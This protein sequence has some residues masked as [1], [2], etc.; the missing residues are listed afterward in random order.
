MQA[1]DLNMFIANGIDPRTKKT[2]A[3]KSMQHFRAAFEPIA[4]KV[5]VADSGALCSPDCTRLTYRSVRR[6][7]YPL[8]TDQTL[9]EGS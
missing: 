8:D 9:C 1:L 6:P 5:V 4:S 7:I 3:L 2:V